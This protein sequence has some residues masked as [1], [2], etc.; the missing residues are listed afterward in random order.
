MGTAASLQS[1]FRGL[2]QIFVVPRTA[3][4]VLA[5]FQASCPLEAVYLA[6]SLQPPCDPS[7]PLIRAAFLLNTPSANRLL[8]RKCCEL[9]PCNFLATLCIFARQPQ[10]GTNL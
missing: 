10:V 9:P 8:N 1:N 3:A 5:S 4:K 6:A 7:L 2:R